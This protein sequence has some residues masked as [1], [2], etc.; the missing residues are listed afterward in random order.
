MD[1]CVHDPRTSN[2]FRTFMLRASISGVASTFSRRAV[3]DPT[4][5]LITNCNGEARGVEL[6]SK[7]AL[8]QQ[9]QRIDW[10]QIGIPYRRTRF[11]SRCWI[12]IDTDVIRLIYG[13]RPHLDVYISSVWTPCFIKKRSPY[14][15]LLVVL[16][17]T[18]RQSAPLPPSPFPLSPSPPIATIQGKILP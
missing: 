3:L 10:V 11:K 5:L 7:R 12:S 14:F 13:R 9:Q 2:D 16:K 6:R 8:R 4:A 18:G 15:A 1:T 17:P